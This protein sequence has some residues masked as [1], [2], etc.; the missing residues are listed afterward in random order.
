MKFYDIQPTDDAILS[1]FEDNLIGR[2]EDLRY[3]VELLNSM[4]NGCS[5]ALDARWGEGKTFFIKHA[6]LVMDAHNAHLSVLET[7][8]KNRVQIAW[9]KIKGNK[10]IELQPHVSVYYDAW[11][12]DND[13]DP[14]LSLV[15]TILQTVSFDAELTKGRKCAEI[16]SNLV[17]AVTG[18]NISAALK[19]LA[20]DDPLAKLRNMKS[21]E[22][23]IAEFL[24]SLLA[25]KGNR[26]V[27]FVDELDRCRPTFAV[28]VL[29]RIKHCF[30]NE[31]ITFVFAVNIG[32]LQHTIKKCYGEGYD[33]C[34]YLDRFF[35]FRVGLPPADKTSFCN[36]IGL[37]NYWTYESVCKAVI[38]ENHMSLREVSKFYR[39]AR[40]AAYS[41]T[42]NIG[43]SHM[44]ET[45]A[46]YFCLICIVPVM[47]GLKVADHTKYEAF[48]S[49]RDKE[50]L[51]RVFRGE[52]VLLGIFEE[53][54]SRDESYE[55]QRANGEV[56]TVLLEEKLT[57]VYEALFVYPYSGSIYEKEI[58][59]IRF[60]EKTKKTLFQV[61]S[62]LSGYADYEV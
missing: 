44:Y 26:L 31:R 19:S 16:A 60:N 9:A 41:A 43:V 46:N 18:R 48:I 33:A 28:Q 4:E 38:A 59:R 40:T 29:E 12:N 34:R 52:D 36:H 10:S 37:N 2:N 13:E 39:L 15:Y 54:L 22:A 21:L 25:E 55:P 11:R 47:L 27:V 49:G 14:I 24:D 62:I 1:S 56:H 32:E 42:H 6:K 45:R 17:D 61:V 3:F 7:D 30:A 5:I 57:A 35:D 23:Q 51:I 50:P 8:E 20:G 53:L 58:G